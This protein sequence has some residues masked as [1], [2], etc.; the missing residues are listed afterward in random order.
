MA[1]KHSVHCTYYRTHSDPSSSRQSRLLTESYC[2]GS[3]YTLCR[4]RQYTI[5]HCQEPPSELAPN[6]YFTGVHNNLRVENTRKFKRHNVENGSCILQVLG[7]DKVFSAWIVDISE[8]GCR[9][10]LTDHPEKLGICVK[11]SL[12]KI[13]GYAIN[14]IPLPIAEVVAKPV[15]QNNRTMGCFFS[16]TL[17]QA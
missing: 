14:A 17:S 5:E 12:F 10:D 6:G 9:L 1:C 11:T 7:T 4:R 16:D 2:E 3:F 8:G 15:W 13:L